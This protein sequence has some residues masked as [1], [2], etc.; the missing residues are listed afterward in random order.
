M[1]VTMALENFICFKEQNFTE[2]LSIFYNCLLTKNELAF[3]IFH[4]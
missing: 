3:T 4:D 1:P 2:G